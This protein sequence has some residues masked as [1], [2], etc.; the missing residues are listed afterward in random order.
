MSR[1]DFDSSQFDDLDFPQQEQDDAERPLSDSSGL[2]PLD[3][4]T[5]PTGASDEGLD[6]PGQPL[7]EEEEPLEFGQPQYAEATEQA[8]PAFPSEGL[9]FPTK[10][11][12]AAEAEAEEEE[13]KEKRPGAMAAWFGSLAQ[14]N[15]YTVLLGIALLA[16]V[17]ACLGFAL[18][19]WSYG[20][21]VGASAARI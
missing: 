21:D 3:F 13:T 7:P 15:P 17:V 5:T 4:P 19:L 18:E 11:T 9:V 12:A 20:F 2:E 16:L 10:T 1:G 6:L 14:S 8:A